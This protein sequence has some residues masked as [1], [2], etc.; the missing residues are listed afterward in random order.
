MIEKYS[1]KNIDDKRLIFIKF[2]LI[3]W[4]ECWLFDVLQLTS[5][6]IYLYSTIYE[7]NSFDV[8][9]DSYLSRSYVVRWISRNETLRESFSRTFVLES[10]AHFVIRSLRVW[11]W[12][13]NRWVRLIEDLAETIEQALLDLGE[14]MRWL[15]VTYPYSGRGR[16]NQLKYWLK[17]N[18]I[19]V[20]TAWTNMRDKH[21][22]FF[23]QLNKKM[24]EMNELTEDYNEQTNKLQNVILII[25]E[26]KIELREKNVKNSN[27]LL[28]I[29]EGDVIVFTSKKLSDSSIFTDDKDLI[30]DDWLLVMRNKMKENANW[31]F[32][33]VQQ[34][35]YVRIRIDDD[36]MKHLIFRFFKNSI[37]S[38]TISKK[39]FENLYQIFDDSNRR[40]NVLKAYRRLKQ[41]ESFKDFNTFWVEFQRLTNDFEL[42]NQK[43]LLEDLKDKMSYE[44]QKTLTIESY[45]TTD[46]HEFVKMCRYTNQILRN[47]NNKS[48][49][50]D[51]S[52]DAE[53]EEVIVI[54]NSNQIK[55]NV[56]RSISRSRF[57]TSEFESESNSRAITQSSSTENQMNSV[58]CYNCEKFDHYSRHCRQLRKMNLNSFVREINVHKKNDSSVENLEIESRKE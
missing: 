15:G 52:D 23:N 50:E 21:A 40:I 11:A 56:E 49:R 9:F 18:E 6:E 2:N 53:R 55:K 3:Y 37:K 22:S 25:R 30:I 4:S 13:L 31:F 29:I 36:V 43:T 47:V 7:M 34:K 39:I 27:T 1:S 41:I 42:Y 12:S 38:Y 28:F 20:V 5:I 24:K 33:D 19:S 58:N 14:A 44:L 8:E 48:R 45:K 17:K 35:A 46:L 26:L 32:T 10:F 51:F 57:E 54:V 16:N